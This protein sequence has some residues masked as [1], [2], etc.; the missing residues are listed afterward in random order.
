[1]NLVRSLPVHPTQHTEDASS[2]APGA[3]P[4]TRIA[5]SVR[6]I[7][8]VNGL[9]L[10]PGFLADSCKLQRVHSLC[11]GNGYICS[12]LLIIGSISEEEE[13]SRRKFRFL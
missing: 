8:G 4:T 9:V 10:T 1:M 6:L 12:S 13:K 2:L 7:A 11:S 5:R 3:L